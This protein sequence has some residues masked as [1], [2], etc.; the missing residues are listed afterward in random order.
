MQFLVDIGNSR[1]KWARIDADGFVPLASAERSSQK[2]EQFATE[3][4]AAL[5][6]PQR[7]VVSNVAGPAVA[8][9]VKAWAQ[10]QWRC[11]V[12]FI[13]AR[14]HGWGVRNGYVEPNRLG[15]DRWAAL[16]GVRQICQSAAYVV[17]AGT[18]LTID[19]LGADGAHQGGLIIPGI[20]LMQR[21]LAER[22]P[23]IRLTTNKDVRRNE[24]LLA[25][26]TAG[27][28]QGGTLYAAVALIDR[29]VQDAEAELGCPLKRIM[30]G[31]DGRRLLPLLAGDFEFHEHLVLQGIGVIA[32]KDT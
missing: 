10:E 31:G 29:V 23:G 14:R 26:D 11:S 4:W 6:A 22:A 7:M 5:D 9:A 3:H 12:E 24:T 25:K 19:I 2:F 1:V 20:G 28:V 21:A 15:A 8:K 32:T 17:D 30:T 18:A 27:A 13:E 16:I